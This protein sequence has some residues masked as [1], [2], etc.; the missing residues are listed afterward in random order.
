ME[1]LSSLQERCEIRVLDFLQL[2]G[3]RIDERDVF[4]AL[5]PFYSPRVITVLK[6]KSG[7]IELWVYDDEISFTART[8][9]GGFEFC[10]Y[11]SVEV[12]LDALLSAV[13]KAL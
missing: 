9:G 10:D 5:V 2:H 1:Q 6:L 13:E 4:E 7:D 3:R 11:G 8:G 12:M